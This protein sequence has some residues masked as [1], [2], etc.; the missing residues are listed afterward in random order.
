MEAQKS[1]KNVVWKTFDFFHKTEWDKPN[2]VKVFSVIVLSFLNT[3][4]IQYLKIEEAHQ[5][6]VVS[7]RKN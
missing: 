2:L 7:V 5:S 3:N 6:L 1:G 4:I